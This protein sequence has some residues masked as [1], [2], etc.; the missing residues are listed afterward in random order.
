MQRRTILCL[1][2]AVV[3]GGGLSAWALTEPS[4]MPAEVR[5]ALPMAQLRGSSTIRF[6]GLV[7]YHA[8]LW[9]EANFDV[10]RF[11]GH[12][13]GLELEYQRKLGGKPIA[14]RSI[15]E[16]RRQPGFAADKAQKWE[17]TMSALFP[18]VAAGERLVG[19]HNPARGARFFH[20]GRLLGDVPDPEFA[21]LFFGIWLS[22]ETSEP[23]VRCALARCL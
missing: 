20:N 23:Q 7:I 17:A 15:S 1:P 3:G 21:K 9:T 18:D 13:F 12:A 14:Q 5:Q 22:P 10:A 19:L 4:A 11:D 16:M 6:F 2:A 8:R